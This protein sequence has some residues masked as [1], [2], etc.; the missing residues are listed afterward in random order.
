MVW[1]TF[2]FEFYVYLASKQKKQKH[3]RKEKEKKTIAAGISTIGN[4]AVHIGFN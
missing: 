1:N 2:Y 3:I 4:T